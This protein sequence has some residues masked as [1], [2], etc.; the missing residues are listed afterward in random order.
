MGLSLSE[1]YLLT[2]RVESNDPSRHP[3]PNF[4]GDED[5]NEGGGG[6]PIGGGGPASGGGS[7]PIATF[8][9]GGGQTAVSSGA[10]EHIVTHATEEDTPQAP[11]VR[12][13]ILRILCKSDTL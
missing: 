9:S 5:Q 13:Y 2:F 6:G 8:A 1:S 7:G 11:V 3:G 4:G 12:P 10:A